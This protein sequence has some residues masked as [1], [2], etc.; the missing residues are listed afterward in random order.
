LAGALAAAKESGALD[1]KTAGGQAVA[2]FVTNLSLDI[3]YKKEIADIA[4]GKAVA[5]IPLLDCAC[6]AS[7]APEHARKLWEDAGKL[8]KAAEDCGKAIAGA[9]L[10]AAS[11]GAEGIK[12][13]IDTFG[14]LLEG[15]GDFFKDLCFWCDSGPSPEQQYADY[16]DA[17][18]VDVCH[19]PS[20][21]K[22]QI[23]SLAAQSAA[24]NSDLVYPV[25]AFEKARDDF[26]KKCLQERCKA[27][28]EL[29]RLLCQGTGGQWALGGCA[30]GGLAGW[31]LC[32]GKSNASWCEPQPCATPQPPPTV[33]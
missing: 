22:E 12:W 28:E 2:A 10:S 32:P 21:S 13:L 20:L 16:L 25:A 5:A 18:L 27:R 15:A 26:A 1:C 8:L 30:E 31:C 19:D 7:Q 23:D 24:N 29:N 9:L 11:Y 17:H 14:G 3:P 6:K 33:K 4:A